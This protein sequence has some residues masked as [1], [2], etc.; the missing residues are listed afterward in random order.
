MLLITMCW[1]CTNQSVTEK[2]QNKRNNII[3]VKDKIKEII[4]DDDDVLIG[5]IARLS[6]IENYLIVANPKTIDKL[7]YIFDKKSF[8]Y[9]TG[10]TYKGQGPGEIANMG[11]LAPDEEN[12]SFYVSD[13]GK[14]LIYAYDLDSVLNNPEYM[15]TIKMKMNKGLFP[16]RYQYINDTLCIGLIIEPI[17]VSDFTQSVGKW[18]M[19][20]EEIQLMKYEHPKIAKKRITFAMSLENNI[21]VECY[22]T[23]DLMTICNL[24]G[25]LK[26]NI[27]GPNWTTTVERNP[28]HY[29]GKAIFC[30][31]KLFASYS[32]GNYHTDEYYPTS[33]LIFD[34]YGNYIKTLETGYKISDFCYD[35]DNN[36]II[37]NLN[38][39]MQFAYLDLDGIIE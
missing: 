31:N 13:H 7:I 35:K 24:N 30:N 17:G 19:N 20:T 1:S 32:G 34:I 33:F 22:S 6:I 29:Y 14:Q 26:Y 4:I 21:Y 11:V 2:Y 37:M 12:R 27:Y 15:P 16:D 25:D 38:S 18:N 10:T 23:Y 8:N 5:P 3:Q 36:R 9:L 28:T 39:E